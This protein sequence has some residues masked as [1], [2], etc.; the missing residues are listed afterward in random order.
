MHTLPF[1]VGLS[2]A[3]FAAALHEQQ[4][5]KTDSCTWSPLVPEYQLTC[6]APFLKQHRPWLRSNVETSKTRH[7]VSEGYEPPERPGAPNLW[8]GPERCSAGFCLF[9]NQ[10]AGGGM[11]LITSPRM[12]HVVADSQDSLL[13]SGI[14]PEA[15]YEVEIPGKGSGLIANRTIRKGE[16]IMQR[17]PALLIQ[18]RPHID[19]EPGLRLEMYQAAVDRLPEPTRTNFLRQTGDTVYEKVEKNSFRVFVDGNTQ[20]SAHLG[21]FPEVSK[22]NHDCRPKF[23]SYP[24]PSFSY[25]TAVP[26]QSPQRAL[27]HIQFHPHHHCG[28]RHS[29]R[30]GADR[31]LHLRHGTACR[32]P[33]AASRVGVY[34]H[35]PAVHP[36]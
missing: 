31:L 11:S 18:N 26:N 7:G 35:L 34:L 6:V 9:Y 36:L 27:S 1:L 32:A 3:G 4:I 12:A 2:A 8:K 15:F 24:S 30:R 21:I 33:R 23:V 10:N 25:M 29:C 22:F 16:I 28:P 17:A 13:S 20:H 14:E 5:G 19:F